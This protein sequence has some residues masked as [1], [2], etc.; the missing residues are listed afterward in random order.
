MAKRSVNF[1][2]A[3]RGDTAADVVSAL[4]L[5]IDDLYPTFDLRLADGRIVQQRGS[6]GADAARRWYKATGDKA[7]GYRRAAC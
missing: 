7:T 5:T 1:H 2:R 3:R 6:D 4:G